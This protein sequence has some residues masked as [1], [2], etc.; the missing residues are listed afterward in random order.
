[1]SDLAAF[2]IG[3]GIGLMVTVAILWQRREEV[4]KALQQR[5]VT[6]GTA[7]SHRRLTI[8]VHALAAL[9]AAYVA[10]EASDSAV[11][12]IGLLVCLV[13]AVSIGALLLQ[14]RRST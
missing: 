11:R 12:A 3:A 1:M 14:S 2:L 10:I 6:P 13:A 8:A 7:F 4:A 5:G 9:V